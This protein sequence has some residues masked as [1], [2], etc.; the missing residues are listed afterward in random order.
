MLSLVIP[1]S[2]AFALTMMLIKESDYFFGRKHFH[3]RN[4][5][6]TTSTNQKSTDDYKDD[7]NGL[8]LSGGT[9]GI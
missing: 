2:L 1:A 7:M 6:A 8:D 3:H 5:K 4:K 9:M